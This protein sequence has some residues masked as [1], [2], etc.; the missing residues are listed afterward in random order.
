VLS[1]ITHPHTHWRNHL[2][3]FLPIKT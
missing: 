2:P 3:L 1:N